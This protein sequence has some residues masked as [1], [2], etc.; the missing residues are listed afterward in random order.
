M[1]NHG[2]EPAHLRGIPF[3]VFASPLFGRTDRHMLYIAFDNRVKGFS[4]GTRRS[5][6]AK[7]AHDVPHDLTTK[8]KMVKSISKFPMQK[9]CTG[10]GQAEKRK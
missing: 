7:S 4:G 8:L 9:S 1:Q 5:F 2:T 6:R 3:V 10:D